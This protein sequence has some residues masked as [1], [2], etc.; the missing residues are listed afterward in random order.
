MS[1]AKLGWQAD[2]AVTE[3]TAIYHVQEFLICI[4][5]F[6]TA[7]TL[8]LQLRNYFLLHLKRITQICMCLCLL[9]I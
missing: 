8:N 9:Y 3:R 4:A 7:L 2:H 1:L 5:S 6:V